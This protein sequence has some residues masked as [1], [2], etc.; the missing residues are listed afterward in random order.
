MLLIFE[1]NIRLLVEEDNF[2]DSY[3]YLCCGKDNK[4]AARH[5]YY[6]P[7]IIVIFRSQGSKLC[8]PEEELSREM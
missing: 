8:I 5:R 4:N 3:F 1:G 7:D 6:D 2:C